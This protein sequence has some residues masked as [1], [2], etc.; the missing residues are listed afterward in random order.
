M[1]G[2]LSFHH[3]CAS[4]LSS[5]PGRGALG[6]PSASG[7]GIASAPGPDPASLFRENIR[8]RWPGGARGGRMAGGLVELEGGLVAGGLVELEG[9]RWPAAWWSSRGSD[10]RRPGGA[11]GG[12]DFPQGNKGPR[13]PV[14]PGKQRTPSSGFPRESKDLEVPCRFPPPGLAP[15]G[16]AIRPRFDRDSTAIRP[17]F[18]RDSTAIRPQFDRDSRQ[19]GR[20]A[21]TKKP[22][23]DV[24]RGG[25]VEPWPASGQPSHSERGTS[26]E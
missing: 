17:Q 2:R 22:R 10:G 18:D 16:G 8:G 4:V 20:S 26:S 25:A 9:V 24:G 19:R 23:H 21:G 1:P 6:G 3:S 13:A 12:P 5:R 11:R 7:I 14:S 15:W